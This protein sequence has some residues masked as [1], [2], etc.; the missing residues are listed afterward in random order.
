VVADIA[1]SF[2]GRTRAADLFGAQ[3]QDLFQGLVSDLMDHGLHHLAGVFD[4]VQDGKQDLPIGS[5]E[6]L[7]NQS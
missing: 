2:A 3:N 1:A 6:L 7:D 4:Q 5:T